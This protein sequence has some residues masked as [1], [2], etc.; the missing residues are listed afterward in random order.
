MPSGGSAARDPQGTGKSFSPMPKKPPESR[1][2]YTIL[3]VSISTTKSSIFP[4]VSPFKL[5]T[6]EPMI[7]FVI[8]AL[9]PG[10]SVVM[11]AFSCPFVLLSK[12][13]RPNEQADNSQKDDYQIPSHFVFLLYFLLVGSTTT[14]SFNSIRPIPFPFSPQYPQIK[15]AQLQFVI[16]R[17]FPPY[18]CSSFLLPS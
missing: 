15:E 4:K 17:H 16:D 11:L 3:P 7:F 2:A 13:T 1:T 12:A 18:P 9:M 8:K 6:L 10:P 14:L 5:I